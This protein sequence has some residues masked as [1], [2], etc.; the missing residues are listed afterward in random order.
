MT[1]APRLSQARQHARAPRASRRRFLT[2]AAAGAIAAPAPARAISALMCP[3]QAGVFAGGA[4]GGGTPHFAEDIDY[5]GAVPDDGPGMRRLTMTNRAT[6]ERFDRP[7]VENGQYVQEALD[8]FSYFARDRRANEVRD[9]DPNTIE[10]I[11]KIWR[12]LD[13]S[14]PFNLNSGYR[15]PTTNASLPGAA[16]QSMHLYAKAADLT[17]SNRSVAQVYN[18]ARAVNGGGVGR[19]TDDNFVHVDSGRVRTW[20]R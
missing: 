3:P 11:W 17:I 1:N 12:K 19:Y 2:L 16:K 9:F 10:I 13:T 18:A 14:A 5:S 20:G 6:G 7:F 4:T 8:E 15:S